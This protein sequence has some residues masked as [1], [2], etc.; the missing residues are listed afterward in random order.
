MSRKNEGSEGAEGGDGRE[1]IPKNAEVRRTWAGKSSGLWCNSENMT[2]VLSGS[3]QERCLEKE[4]YMRRNWAC[5]GINNRQCGL[6]VSP[7]LES[8]KQC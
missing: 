3:L 4:S 6:S 1:L 2:G 5:S 7:I 8:Q